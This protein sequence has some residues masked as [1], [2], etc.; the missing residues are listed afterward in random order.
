MLVRLLHRPSGAL[1]D[2][3]REG[4]NVSVDAGAIERREIRVAVL[5]PNDGPCIS[6]RAEHGVHQEPG[7]AAVAIRVWVN[8]AE[9]PMRENRA[10]AWIRFFFEKIEQRRH[11]VAHGFPSWRH[12][13]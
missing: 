5:Y 6:A 13:A 4:R 12:V 8:V 2:E 11:G 9:Q 1:S 10:N 7:H 3:F